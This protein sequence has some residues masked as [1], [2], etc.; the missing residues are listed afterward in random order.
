MEKLLC[1]SRRGSRSVVKGRNGSNRARSRE[2]QW[3]VAAQLFPLSI[4]AVRQVLPFNSSDVSFPLSITDSSPLRFL[5]FIPP[6]HEISKC[7][8]FQSWQEVI[9]ICED[10]FQVQPSLHNLF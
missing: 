9:L 6:L 8:S 3:E 7:R 10:E 4:P 2:Q 1:S 5:P